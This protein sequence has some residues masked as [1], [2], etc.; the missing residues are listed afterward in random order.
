M[1]KS[2]KVLQPMRF[3]DAYCDFTPVQKDFIMLVQHWTSKQKEIINDFTIDLKPYF[4]AKGQKLED[5]RQAHYTE[6]TDDLLKS[7][8]TFKYMK[9]DTLF[10]MYNLFSRCTVDKNLILSVSIVDEVLPLF[11]I[12][13]L[14]EGHFQDN[15]LVKELFQ[16]SYP[17]YDKYIS[18][19][20]KTF[21]DFRE[22]QS[23]KLFEKLLQ[24]RRLKKYSFEFAKDEL[25]LMLGYGYLRDKK[26][27]TLPQQLFKIK[28]QEFVQTAYIGVDG[29]KNLRAKLNKWL[30]EISER[31][32]TGIQVLKKGKNYFS[33]RGRPIRSIF[34]NVEYDE[35]LA[36]LT[37]DQQKGFD[38]LLSY[39]LSTKQS[40][41]IVTDFDHSSI[42]H[43]ISNSVVAKR[44]AQ[45]NR[46]YG[47]YQRPDHRRIDN[48]PG[49]IYGIVFGYG[50]K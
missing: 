49:Y 11:Y 3:V 20:P 1:N 10:T 48:V 8:V 33:T 12:N 7:K 35:E 27:P 39:G 9:G 25:Y 29:W 16:Q 18:Y 19:Y 37:E 4:L 32:D 44:D 45:G 2:K 14:E 46:Y 50:K 30:E 34:I 41:R 15:R 43:R 5:I 36:E 17:E 47:E 26:E 40:F 24:Y 42:L 21:I 31:E 22:S 13:K 28:G 6:L 23:K 38:Y